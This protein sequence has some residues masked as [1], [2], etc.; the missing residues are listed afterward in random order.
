MEWPM[1]ESKPGVDKVDKNDAGKGA[2]ERDRAEDPKSKP[3]ELDDQGQPIDKTT[4]CEDA[5][6]ANVDQTEG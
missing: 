3:P 5:I 4:V 1:T 6:G 2:V